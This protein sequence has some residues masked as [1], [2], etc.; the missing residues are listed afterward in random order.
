MDRT[1]DTSSA[2][3]EVQEIEVS[4]QGPAGDDLA[5]HAR[6][7]LQPLMERIGVPVQRAHLHLSVAAA[8]IRH[9][10]TDAR[11]EVFLDHDVIHAHASG[12]DP[13]AAIDG[14]HQH[15]SSQVEEIRSRRR[16]LRRRGPASGPG[17]WR[18]GDSSNPG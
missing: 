15:L 1:T 2:S 6:I 5:E 7:R 16:T 9:R 4:V 18:H 10:A 13:V 17:E 14:V 12:P 3:P 8:P 11:L